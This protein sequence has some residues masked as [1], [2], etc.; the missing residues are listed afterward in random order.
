M[1]RRVLVLILSA[2]GLLPV[3]REVPRSAV[4]LAFSDA[5]PQ[6]PPSGNAAAVTLPAREVLERY[7]ITC[8]NQRLKT[9]GLALDTMDLAKV[10]DSAEVWEKVVRKL[11]TGAMPPAGRPRPDQA[12]YDAASSW[13]EG[14]L[15]RAAVAHPNPGR[16]TLHRLNRTEYLNAV[17]DLLGLDIAAESLLPPDNAGYGF[18]NIGDV[19]SL[20][21]ALTERYLGAAAKISQMAIG[22]VKGSPSPETYSRSRLI[23]TSKAG[24]ARICPSGPVA[25]QRFATSF[26]LM[27]S[28]C[29]KY[30]CT[31]RLPGCG[32]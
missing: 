17:R 21:P 26:P 4:T 11:R 25:E 8:H 18:D 22:R 27:A 20:S 29:S 13:L 14:E 23:S 3:G 19:L 31:K 28:T 1:I 32:G 7:C 16:P 12:L 30:D 9:A 24:S 5:A 15:D 2:T 6:Q 10:G